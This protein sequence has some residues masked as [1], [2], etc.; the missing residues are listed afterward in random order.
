MTIENKALVAV[1]IALGAVIIFKIIVPAVAS[2][3]RKRRRN[4]A[5]REYLKQRKDMVKF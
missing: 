3:F 2:Y 5:Y 4:K 1:L